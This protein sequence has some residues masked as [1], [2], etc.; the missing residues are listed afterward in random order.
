MS[1]I[2]IT[3]LFIDLVPAFATNMC[4]NK[5]TYL[6]TYMKPILKNATFECI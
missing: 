6:H 4:F 5:L 2:F 3:F 1:V